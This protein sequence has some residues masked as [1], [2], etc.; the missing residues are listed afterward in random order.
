M[1][2]NHTVLAFPVRFEVRR[3]RLRYLSSYVALAS[4]WQ[5]SSQQLIQHYPNSPE[6]CRG[7]IDPK[8]WRVRICSLELQLKGPQQLWSSIWY[9][10]TVRNDISHLGIC[11]QANA[12]SESKM[13]KRAWLTI[14]QSVCNAREAAALATDDG[15]PHKHKR[16]SVVGV[17]T[18]NKAADVPC[19]QEGS[20]HKAHHVYLGCIVGCC[21]NLSTAL[22]PMLHISDY[23]A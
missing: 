18:C 16:A 21:Q 13:V 14:R 15:Q 23:V 20:A 12:R 1:I 9:C 6:V 22:D 7:T 10:C 3:H 5:L 17:F 2:L 11:T 8:I 4:K 19:R